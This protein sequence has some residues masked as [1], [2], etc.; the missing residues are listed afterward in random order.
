MNFCKFGTFK[1]LIF[2]HNKQKN[3]EFFPRFEIDIKLEQ[4]DLSLS[5]IAPYV[6]KMIEVL[7]AF[8]KHPGYWPTDPIMS[9][10]GQLDQT[11]WP[12]DFIFE[13]G[14]EDD[15][16]K[17][18]EDWPKLFPNFPGPDI[19]T[20]EKMRATYYS[21]VNFLKD[22]RRSKSLW[23]RLHNSPPSDFWSMVLLEMK[24]FLDDGF[25]RLLKATLSVPYGSGKYI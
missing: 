18:F 14:Q 9:T 15:I 12:L 7:D 17:S 3:L 10:L 19:L 5:F 24:D 22:T 25:V 16:I 2:P 11:L 6:N 21:I 20:K 4:F 13:D 23:C 8:G 1:N